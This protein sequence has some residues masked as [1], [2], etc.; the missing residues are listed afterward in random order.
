MKQ[1]IDDKTN[2]VTFF[3]FYIA[4]TIELMILL[5]DKSAYINPIEGRLFQITFV[6]FGI[7]ILGTKYSLKE[8]GVLVLFGVLGAISYFLTGR[9]EIL[10]VVVFLAA[11]KQMQVRQLIRYTFIVV[12]I[13]I[14]ILIVLSLAGVLG[15]IAITDDFGRG[16]VETRYA[17]GIGH[18][19]ALHCMYWTLLT[20]FL[21]LYNSKLRWWIYLSLYGSNFILY[22]LTISKSGVLITLFTISIFLFFR[23]R[24]SFFKNRIV[25]IFG[26]VT[27][28][29][30]CLVS[31]L[32]AIPI[33]LF[34]PV[35]T[36]DRMLTGRL[37]AASLYGNLNTW[38]LFSNPNNTEFFDMGFVR[39]FYWYGVI[40]AMLAIIV[41]CVLL[42]STWKNN[43]ISG[44]LLV[45]SF[46]LY[47]T[48]EAHAVS[49]YLARNHT[50]LILGTTW[51]NLVQRDHKQ[52]F[53]IWQ[54][55]NYS[56]KIKG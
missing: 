33:A 49:V 27:T 53:Y 20:L 16:A 52:D 42:Y 50:L 28:L 39:L 34:A 21:Y 25:P 7:V 6:L 14:G 44:F 47:T 43:D 3:I 35:G 55:T 2:K 13:G 54:I 48:L 56:H 38:S 22:A 24:T 1:T 18:P 12:G 30:C 5:I 31:V 40:P 51:F 15:N 41:L 36:I 45:L 9:N 11:C 10:R 17:L 29:T 26:I 37:W 23:Y 32:A 8:F 46:I 19:N 4:Y